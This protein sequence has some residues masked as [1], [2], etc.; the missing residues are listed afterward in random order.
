MKIMGE[1]WGVQ[2]KYM[3]QTV[4]HDMYEQFGWQ[5]FDAS[6][7]ERHCE[8]VQRAGFKKNAFDALQ[9]QWSAH[10]SKHWQASF[11]EFGYTL[12]ADS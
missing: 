2:W 3:Q 7:F 6:R 11:R 10:V 12:K 9:P 8:S 5:G 1:K 4:L